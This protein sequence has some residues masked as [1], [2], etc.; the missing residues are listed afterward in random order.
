MA[1]E[2]ERT[3][4]VISRMNYVVLYQINSVQVTGSAGTKSTME[5]GLNEASSKL[6]D[7]WTNPN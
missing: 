1:A 4:P 5:Q 7:H 6:R 3:A 2:A